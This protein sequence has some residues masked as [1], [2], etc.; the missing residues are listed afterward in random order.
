MSTTWLVVVA[1]GRGERLGRAEPTALVPLAGR[2]LVAYCLEAAAASREIER[3]VGVGDVEAL[4]QLATTLS[5]AARRKW[6]GAVSGGETR[7]DSVRAGLLAVR[8]LDPGDP[9]VLVHDA[10]RPLAP[11]SLFDAVAQAAARGPALAAAA[12][13]DTVKEVIGGRVARTLDRAS[14]ALAQTPQGAR[15]G[16]LLAA[17]E[18]ART[19]AATDDASLFEGTSD[20]PVIVPGPATNRKVTTPEDLLLVEAW[21]AAGGA[22]WMTSGARAESHA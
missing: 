10:A 9:V 4:G 3:I 17:H 15:L 5:P 8:R 11:P 19:R 7:Q 1:G 2:P 20:P 13:A 6:T 21:V 18:G 14:L 22:P 16:A 12:V